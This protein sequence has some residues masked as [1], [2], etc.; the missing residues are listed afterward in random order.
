[1]ADILASIA[2]IINTNR[3]VYIDKLPDSP[4]T[5]VC[6]YASG[7]GS[8]HDNFGITQQ[9]Q[10][11]AK[12]RTF[13]VRSRAAKY[14]EMEARLTVEKIIDELNFYK[15]EDADFIIHAVR[16]MSGPLPM[17]RDDKERPEYTANFIIDYKAKQP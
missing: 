3:T 15:G 9:G 5:A 14:G 1:M 8:T 16:Y 6:L 17:G 10:T 12:E 13:Q 4:D 11:Q 2:N 7:S